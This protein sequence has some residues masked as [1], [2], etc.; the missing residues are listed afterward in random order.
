MFPRRAKLTTARW[1]M[2]EASKTGDQAECERLL[3]KADALK[4]ATAG[5]RKSAQRIRM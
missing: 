2:I 1:P 5:V 4:N 3:A